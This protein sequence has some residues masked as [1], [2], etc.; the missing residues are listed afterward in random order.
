MRRGVEN[1]RAEK[2]TRSTR[3]DSM[4]VD[5][6]DRDDCEAKTSSCN[7]ASGVAD[8]IDAG[9][10]ERLEESWLKKPCGSLWSSPSS[11]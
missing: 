10:K 5:V 3:L 11:S 9:V 2:R 7:R 4:G 1:S 6:G 8:R